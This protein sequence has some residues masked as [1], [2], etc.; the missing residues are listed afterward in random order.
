MLM[1]VYSEP[2]ANGGTDYYAVRMM[3]K[4]RYSKDSN[5]LI[6]FE[7]VGDLYAEN[8]K[9]IPRVNLRLPQNASHL[10]R[11]TVSAYSIANLI[12]DVKNDFG[13][14]F[15]TGAYQKV[16]L[17][18]EW[19]AHFSDHLVYSL[20]SDEARLRSG[21][22]AWMGARGAQMAQG[23][24]VPLRVPGTGTHLISAE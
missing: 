5:S 17:Q 13:D 7:V 1:S 8:A 23:F 21:I 12:V 2:N 3:V 6:D 4:D 20:P 14:T 10:G 9:K 15:S 19:N 22:F 11:T 16:G 24:R 18:R